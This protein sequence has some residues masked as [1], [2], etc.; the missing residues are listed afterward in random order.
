MIAMTSFVMAG[1]GYGPGD[2]ASDFSLKNVD[3]KTVSLASMNDAKGAIIIFTCNHCPFSKAYED[4]IIALDRQF[5]P[6]G[7][8]VVAINSND[9]AVEPEDSFD[10]MIVRSK[11]KGFTF[12]YLLD[13]TQEVAKKYGAAR[14]PHVYI[15]SREGKKLKVEYVGAID[16]SPYEPEKV[17]S[18]F[19]EDALNSLIKGETLKTL[20]TKAVGCSIKWKKS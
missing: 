14:T 20:S 16:D 5:A 8:P 18:R 19:V 2:K 10:N 13:D 15:V 12:P 3:G 17:T 6:K 7:Y 11:E 4:R 9:A 1:N